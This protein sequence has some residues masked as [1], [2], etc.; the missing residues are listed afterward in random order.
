[1]IQSSNRFAPA[2]NGSW[3]SLRRALQFDTA[4]G[5]LITSRHDPTPRRVALVRLVTRGLRNKESRRNAITEGTGKMHL[6]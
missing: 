1:M 2:N 4:S 5:N 3:R 6:S